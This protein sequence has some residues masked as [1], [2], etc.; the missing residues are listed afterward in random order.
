MRTKERV[1]PLKV[2]SASVNESITLLFESSSYIVSSYE[3]PSNPSKS[4]ETKLPQ[5]SKLGVIKDGVGSAKR[6][7][8]GSRIS[9]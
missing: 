7:K 6:K 3:T 4:K 9:I 5:T 8:Q 1:D 2:K